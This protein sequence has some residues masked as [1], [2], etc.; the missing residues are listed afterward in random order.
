[1]GRLKKLAHDHIH[2]L[3]HP[4]N[5]KAKNK[6]I[7]LE[8]CRNVCLELWKSQKHF[9]TKWR[10]PENKPPSDCFDL[11]KLV[12]TLNVGISIIPNI[13]QNIKKTI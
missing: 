10:L 7:N 2:D 11:K 3:N 13:D 5:V 12:K 1:M 4:N 9:F 6:I 8:K